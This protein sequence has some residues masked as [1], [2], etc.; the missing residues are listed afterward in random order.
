MK[1][2]RTRQQH[3]Y[4]MVLEAKASKLSSQVTLCLKSGKMDQVLS[5]TLTFSEITDSAVVLLIGT[6]WADFFSSW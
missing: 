1:W 3:N 2:I 5:V 4:R 6:L